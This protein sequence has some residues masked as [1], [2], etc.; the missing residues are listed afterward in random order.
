MIISLIVAM[1]INRGIGFCNRLPWKLSDDLKKFKALTWGHHLILG[2]KTF[3]SIGRPLVGRTMIIVTRQK[4]YYREGCLVA[5]SLEQAI[6]LARQAGES[7]VFVGGGA[8][9]YAQV[10]PRADRLYVT[11]VHAEVEADTFFP[12]IEEHQWSEQDSLFYPADEKN[13]YS[14]TVKVLTRKPRTTL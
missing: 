12:V 9:I 7:E 14:F 2:R 3:E 5:H 4:D 11:M 13:E 10:L 1:S 6:A 8:E